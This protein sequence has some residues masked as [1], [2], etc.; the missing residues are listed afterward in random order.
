MNA[1]SCRP[2]TAALGQGHAG[3][4]L[5]QV[6]IGTHHETIQPETSIKF[7]HTAPV[8][9]AETIGRPPLRRHEYAVMAQAWPENAITAVVPTA[10]GGA[11]GTIANESVA[12]GAPDGDGWRQQKSRLNDRHPPLDGSKSP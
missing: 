9:A 3:F 10:A 2:K 8:V 7:E 11:N 1:A 4:K 5:Q 12:H 6:K